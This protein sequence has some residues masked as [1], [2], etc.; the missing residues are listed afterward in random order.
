M[1]CARGAYRLKAAGA[2][3]KVVLLATGSE[4]EIALAC[5]AEL[6]A[7]G[8]GADVVS[9]PCWELFDEQD[10]AYR[11][12]V[13]DR[14]TVRVAVEAAVRQGWDRYIGEDGGFVGMS[15]YGASGPEQALFRHFGITPEAVAE[16]VR[17]RLSS[18]SVST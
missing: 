3:R 10:T 16:E 18:I 7:A 17:K 13:I 1:L 4:V 5:A 15:G 9:M 14:G 8:I 2:D 11:A 6:E 12:R